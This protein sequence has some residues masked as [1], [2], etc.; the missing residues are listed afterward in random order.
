MIAGDIKG[1]YNVEWVKVA[2]LLHWLEDD[3]L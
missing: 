3:S 1:D 2:T